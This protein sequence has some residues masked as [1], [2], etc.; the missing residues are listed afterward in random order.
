MIFLAYITL[1]HTTLYNP[2]RCLA[3]AYARL[4]ETKRRRYRITTLQ[5]L[6]RSLII[7]ECGYTPL[8]IQIPFK[9]CLQFDSALHTKF[10]KEINHTLTQPAHTTFLSRDNNGL[11][12]LSLLLIQLQGRA[13]EL[14]V[15]LNSPDPTQQAPPPRLERIAVMAN[16]SH[17]HRNLIRDAI[18]SLKI[19]RLH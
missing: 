2:V 7:S 5:M 6:L 19:Y 11:Y 17:Q 18:V 16:T 3:V 8:Y 12:I 4:I 15:R 9:K 1:S 14:D 10:I 13:R